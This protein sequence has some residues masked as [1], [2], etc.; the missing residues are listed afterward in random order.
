M[1]DKFDDD[2][3]RLCVEGVPN[4]RWSKEGEMVKAWSRAAAYNEWKELVVEAA[5]KWVKCK[6]RYHSEKNMDVLIELFKKEPE[7]K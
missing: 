6:G 3:E 5:R 4:R 1:S 7:K 2:C